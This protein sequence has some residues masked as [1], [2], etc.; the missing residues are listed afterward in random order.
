MHTLAE[1]SINTLANHSG[2]LI[3]HTID[4]MS[5]LLDDA[6]V[7][8]LLILMA[9]CVHSKRTTSKQLWSDVCRKLV[10]IIG[11]RWLSSRPH[12]LC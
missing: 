7:G 8:W 3:H 4:V 12:S 1:D 10:L 2:T 9:S 11:S 5:T 6:V